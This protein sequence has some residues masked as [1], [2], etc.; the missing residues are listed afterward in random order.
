MSPR[1]RI[2]AIFLLKIDFMDA[3]VVCSEGFVK[4]EK[5]VIHHM[6]C[7]LSK[8]VGAIGVEPMTFWV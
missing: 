8:M 6:G 1:D 7:R 3:T 4:I 5:N 2:E